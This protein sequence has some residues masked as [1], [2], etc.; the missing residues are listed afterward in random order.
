[1]VLNT[2][3]GKIIINLDISA[4]CLN[5]AG[6]LVLCMRHSINFLYEKYNNIFVL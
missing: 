3:S 2:N 1:M 4:F 5:T 6:E